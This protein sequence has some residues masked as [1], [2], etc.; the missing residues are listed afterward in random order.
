MEVMT[1]S[2]CACSRSA[3]REF[4]HTRARMFQTRV[5]NGRKAFYKVSLGG[6]VLW[7]GHHEFLPMRS[8][9][10]NPA[11]DAWAAQPWSAP[12]VRATTQG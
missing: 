7:S 9:Q 12:Q 6:A 5:R 4:C 11:W 10:F 2:G 1:P 8:C 3:W